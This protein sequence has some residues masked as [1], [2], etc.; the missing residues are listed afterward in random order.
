VQSSGT[1]TL[2]NNGFSAAPGST[3][4]YEIWKSPEPVAV[5]T[6]AGSTTS[7]ACTGRS[8]ANDYFND[9]YLCPISGSNRGYVRK[10]TD[11]ASATSFTVDAF[12]SSWASGDVALIR[13]FVDVSAVQDGLNWEYVPRGM[14]RVNGSVGD[15]LPGGKG[16]TFGF[17]TQIR[18][19]SY[20]ITDAVQPAVS[21]IGHLLVACGFEER[22]GTCETSTG[23]GTNTTFPVS[24]CELFQIGDPITY[25]GNTAFVTAISAASGAGTLTVAPGFVQGLSSTTVVPLINELCG[26]ARMYKKSTS[27]DCLG[28]TIEHEVDGIRTT[29]TDCKGNVTLQDSGTGALTMSFDFTPDFWI[30][31]VEAAPYDAVATYTTSLPV[32]GHDRTAFFDSTYANIGALTATLG[33][34]VVKRDIQGSYGINGSA[35]T[36]IT[37]FNPSVTIRE[38]L[39]SS[40]A[41]VAPEIRWRYRTGR[42]F[43]CIWGQHT[44]QF[45]V[46]IGA[47]SAVDYPKHSDVNGMQGAPTTLAPSDAGRSTVTATIGQKTPEFMFF[48]Y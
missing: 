33:T 10:I 35:G 20:T 17:T 18:P 5:A 48:I 6:G 13:R 39:D 31:D 44:R 3:I 28:V 12:P 32:L 19:T 34:T 9:Y 1:F 47:A 36:Q 27:F 24:L 42:V 38:L 4:Y 37:G 8:E 11:F 41:Y 7:F 46:Y 45:G 30:R 26:A 29:M 15:G 14:P 23:T 22:V 2:E 16:G 43:A 40:V 25:Q 21:D